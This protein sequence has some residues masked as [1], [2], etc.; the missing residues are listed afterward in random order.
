[1][2]F[3]SFGYD[4]ALQV[5]GAP[6]WKWPGGQTTFRVRMLS[7]STEPFWMATS[8]PTCGHDVT[9]VLVQLLPPWLA[10]GAPS[11]VNRIPAVAVLE[12]WATVLLI[13]S[14]LSEST[15]EIAA[16]SHPPTL[17]A[18]MLLVRVTP[19]QFSGLRGKATTSDPLTA[20]KAIPPP[21]P[22][23][24]PF[25]MIRFALIRRFGP[26]PS[27][28]PMPAATIWPGPDGGGQSASKFALLL[29]SI[30]A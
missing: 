8:P 15:S 25:P 22:A 4:T 29:Q 12:L 14:T 27:L 9:L 6:G 20:W 2:S 21:V 17:S 24:A 19:F 30:S 3:S 13:M 5:A 1:M 11:V 10:R 7:V 16:P 23:S 28:G 26:M 18:M